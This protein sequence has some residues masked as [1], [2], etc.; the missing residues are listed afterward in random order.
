MKFDRFK[1][2][3]VEDPEGYVLEFVKRIE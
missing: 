1:V 2:F 3:L